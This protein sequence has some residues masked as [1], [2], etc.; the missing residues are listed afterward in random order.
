MHI[1][2]IKIQINKTVFIDKNTKSEID[3]NS[4]EK[5]FRQRLKYLKNISRKSNPSNCKHKLLKL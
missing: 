5:D 4:M 1:I 3:F 2:K